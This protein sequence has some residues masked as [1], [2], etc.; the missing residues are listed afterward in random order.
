MNTM[1]RLCGVF[2][3]TVV[4]NACGAI[5]V[6]TDFNPEWQMPA[7]PSYAWMKRPSNKLDPMVDNDLVE[8][9]VHRAVDEQLA[10]KGFALAASEGA[11]NV[12]VTYHIGEEEKLDINSFHSSYGYYPCWHCW[13]PRYDSDIWVSQY[14]EGKLVI[15][16]VDAQTKKLVWRGAAE[17][18]VPSFKTP[19]ERDTYMRQTVTAIFQKF[20]PN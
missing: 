2:L 17:R 4:L 20:T 18:R 8:A 11:A 5:P 16:I 15:D 9:R 1:L 10:A 6:S 7:S 3:T 19:Q 14:T 12:L 13:G